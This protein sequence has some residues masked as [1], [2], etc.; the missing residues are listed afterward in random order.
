MMEND[1]SKY[2]PFSDN[3]DPSLAYSKPKD[4]TICDDCK[5]VLN[6]DII[7]KVLN[8]L[9]GRKL[10]CLSIHGLKL[11]GLD[12]ADSDLDMKGVF[13]PTERELLLGSYPRVLKYSSG[14][15]N[16]KNTKED[17]EFEKV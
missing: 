15:P 16:G 12:H 3:Y 11:Y 8:V 4:M 5:T 17:Y 9:D 7:Q 10:L 6:G 2:D 1:L 14:D 13:M